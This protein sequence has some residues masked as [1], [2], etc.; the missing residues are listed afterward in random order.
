MAL[1]L[2]ALTSCWSSE[3]D[4]KVRVGYMA[5]PTGMGM[6]KLISDNGGLENGND[7]YTFT[8]YADT[9]VAKYDFAN[10]NIDII[11]LP[12]NEAAAYFNE[13]DSNAKILAIN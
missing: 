1:I 8:K 2:T 12:T 7:K 5:G 11:C 9:T 3:P 10:G 13:V 6:A 4:T